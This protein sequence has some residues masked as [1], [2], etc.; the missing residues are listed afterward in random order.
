MRRL[1][2]VLLALGLLAG[3]GG[4]PAAAPTE[5]PSSPST[6]SGS[7]TAPGLPAPPTPEEIVADPAAMLGD[8]AISPSDDKLRATTWSWC[9]SRESCD[10]RRYAVAVTTDGFTTRQV[11]ALPPLD[12]LAVVPA[13]EDRFLVLHSAKRAWLADGDGRLTPMPAPSAAAPLRAGEEV[14]AFGLRYLAFDPV[15]GARHRLPLPAGL[16][17]LVLTTGGQLRGTSFDGETGRGTYHW[18]D[19][20]GATWRHSELRYG[21]NPLP[22]LP[23]SA[24]DQ[25]HAVVESGD[26]ATLLPLVALLHSADPAAGW[27]RTTDLTDPML[28][29][30]GFGV[31]PDGRM[32]VAA[33]TGTRNDPQRRAG[34]YLTDADWTRLEQLR[35]GPPFAEAAFPGASAVVEIRADLISVTTTDAQGT[36]W[37]TTDLGSTWNRLRV[38]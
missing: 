2:V 27:R 26:G 31:L 21:P 16:N 20:G 10:D 34:L 15:T 23:A 12:W 24:S 35:L 32:L 13:G 8:I 19:D 6:P 9:Q 30:T 37:T 1:G 17:D 18:S 14:S 7:A 25:S 38:R 3:C 29:G 33:E 5:T 36:A 22:V 4:E 11:L 28:F